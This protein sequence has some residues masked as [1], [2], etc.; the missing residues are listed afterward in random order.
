MIG[1]FAG[2]YALGFSINTLTLFGMI[3]AVGIVVDDAIVVV[4]NVE[5]HMALGLRPREAA[6][7]AMEE[8][9]GP[10][11][12]IVLVLCSVF[13]PVAF[14]GGITGELY[15]QFAITIAMSVTISGLVAL[16]LSPALSAVIL[17]PGHSEPNR[18]FRLFNRL[19][20]RIRDGYSAAVAGMLKRSLLFVGIFGVVL[21][22]SIGMFKFIPSGFAGRGPG[23]LY[24]DG[25]ASRRRFQTADR[26]GA[27]A[28]GELFPPDPRIRHTNVLSGQ[29]FVFSTRGPNAA[30]I[31]LPLKDWDERTDPRDHV[32]SI[33]GTAFGEFAK[34]PEALVLAFNPPIRGLGAT[35]I[36][37]AA[38]RPAREISGPSPMR[39]RNS[40]PRPV[41][42]RRSGDRDQLPRQRPG[43]T[44]R[45]TASGRRRSGCR[46][47]ISSTRCRPISEIS[48]ST[49]LSNRGG[50]IGCKPK[51]TRSTAPAQ[52]I[53]RIST[54]GRR[55]GR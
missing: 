21:F 20:D 11:I 6:K 27:G 2:M 51:R 17:K 38:A 5:R 47:P 12:A 15:K 46:S 45:S 43:F 13:I 33:I 23:L 7:K 3:L 54:S 1:T 24:R 30:T 18:F 34:I 19:F 22:L 52:T 31:F 9:T 28:A 48:T 41:K 4:E 55:T 37:R 25:P 36:L 49:T 26:R 44:P 35:G 42:N 53:S 16:T 8:V 14:L 40:S 39:R 10:V 29:N 32:K 50:S